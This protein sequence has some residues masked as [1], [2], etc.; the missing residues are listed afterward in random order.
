M[1]LAAE[2]LARDDRVYGPV[3]SVKAARGAAMLDRSRREAERGQLPEAKHA[4]L[5]GCDGDNRRIHR[6]LTT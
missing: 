5:N 6:S 1:S 4:V 3:D 2:Q